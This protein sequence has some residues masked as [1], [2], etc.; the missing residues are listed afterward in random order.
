M[1]GPLVLPRFAVLSVYHRHAV[2]S[3]AFRP[4][5]KEVA[6][7]NLSEIRSRIEETTGLSVDKEGL[8]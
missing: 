2:Y 8:Q 7:G 5:G 3:A 1:L 4:D 6:L